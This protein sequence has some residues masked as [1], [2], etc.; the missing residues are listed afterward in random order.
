MTV[1]S[2]KRRN[3]HANIRLGTVDADSKSGAVGGLVNLR[4]A[5]ATSKKSEV[6]RAQFDNVCWLCV[7]YI[8]TGRDCRV[9]HRVGGELSGVRVR[10]D[11]LSSPILMA[12]LTGVGFHVTDK[13]SPSLSS[14]G[15]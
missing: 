2:S 8:V 15:Y 5:E 7:A 13:W 6:I 11:H 4:T 3:V 10:V 9:L 14:G 12:R 1:D